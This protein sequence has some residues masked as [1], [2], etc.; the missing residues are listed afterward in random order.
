VVASL[1]GLSYGRLLGNV[2]A[3][4][5]LM[6]GVFMALSQL[7]IAPA[8]VNGLFYAILAV[9]AGSAIIAIG[10][11]G[12][13]PM[14]VRWEQALST[15]DREKDNVRR[16]VSSTGTEDIKAR[17]RQQQEDLHDDTPDRTG[18]TIELPEEEPTR[19]P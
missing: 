2:A 9:L 15:Y 17:V 14:R 10:G 13:Q 1:G 8:I 12:I 3:G 19:R 7:E 5:I 11:G 18:R 4:A 16:E 6:V